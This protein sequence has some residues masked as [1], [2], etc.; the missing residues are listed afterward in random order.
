[1]STV[2]E[3]VNAA[4]ALPP[5]GQAEL[6]RRL[7]GLVATQNNGGVHTEDESRQQREELHLR[8]HRALYEAGL[9]T[10]V[11]PPVKRR[12]ERAPLIRIKGK[13]LSETVIEDRR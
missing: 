3:I 4:R 8:I 10:E 11:D 9:V 6:R 7:D 13:P 1:M 12:R 2:E 5:E